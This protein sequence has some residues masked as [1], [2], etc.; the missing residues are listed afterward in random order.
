MAEANT[1]GLPYVPLVPFNGT[2]AKGGDSLSVDMNLWYQV[3]SSPEP[4]VP[5]HRIERPKIR[6]D[7]PTDAAS[8][9][10]VWRYRVDDHGYCSCATYDSRSWVS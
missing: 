2:E 8:N 3:S 10:T 7:Y 5:L 1:E 9:K 4:A 6:E